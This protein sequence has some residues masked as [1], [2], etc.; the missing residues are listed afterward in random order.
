VE[1]LQDLGDV[2]GV[3]SLLELLIDGFEVVMAD[4]V[5]EGRGLLRRL[6]SVPTL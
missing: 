1:F 5:G 2:G 3:A 6:T 4:G